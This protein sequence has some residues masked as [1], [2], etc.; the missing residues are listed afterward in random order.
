MRFQI[1]TNFQGGIAPG[2]DFV[3]YGTV[4]NKNMADY[5][6]NIDITNPN[7]ISQGPGIA[8]VTNGTNAGAVTTLIKGMLE[9]P[10]SSLTSYGTGGAKLYKMTSDGATTTVVTV[11]SGGDWPHTIDK[12]AVTGEMGEDVAV[13]QGNLYY[14]YNHS[15]SAGDIGKFNLSS[16]FDD[17]WGSTVPTGAAALA[18]APHQMIVG[19]NDV[20]Y[21]ANGRYIG[22]YDGTTFDA[23]ALDLPTGFVVQS[24]AW[25]NDRLWISARSSSMTISGNRVPSS[26][27]IW[28]GTTETW[29]YEIPVNGASGALYVKNG[30]VYLFYQDNFITVGSKL[31]YVNNGGIHDLADYGL[32]LPA[33]YQVSD[34]KNFLIWVGGTVGYV[35]AY[36]SA[37]RDLPVKLFQYMYAGSAGVG[38]LVNVFS[39]PLIASTASTFS[40]NQFS[41]YATAGAIGTEWRSILF[42][43]TGYGRVSKIEGVRINF[44]VLTS[45]AYVDFKLINNKGITLYSDTISFAKLGAVTSVFYP[46]N[47]KVAENFQMQFAYTSGSASATVKLKNARIWGSID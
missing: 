3:D 1:E 15:G 6:A 10:A 42:D 5:I 46:L 33:Y 36:G 35:Y 12:A 24:I 27:F 44:E 34:Y 43:I 32:G 37:H 7:Y 47:G 39:I 23:Q 41:G 11:T 17:D 21:F 19:G 2:G 13:Y 14:S 31:A 18:D 22:N 16:T 25:N 20:L 30:T 38:G 4:G 28:D 40:L 45:G 9:A 29:E 26:V 8:A